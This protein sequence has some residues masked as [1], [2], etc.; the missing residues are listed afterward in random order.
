MSKK[1]RGVF[2]K[3][4]GSGVWWIHYYDADGHRRRERVGSKSNA[5][6]LYQK[7]KTQ[8]WEGMKVPENLRARPVTF[9]DLAT[10]AL[11]YSKSRK[12][13]SHRDDQSRMKK[14]REKF[15]HCVAEKITPQE[16]EG[17]L[18]S[19]ADWMPATKNRYLAL[20]KLTYRLG[21]LNGKIRTSP[22]RLV[23][24]RRENNAVVR[25]LNQFEPLPTQLDYLK[26]HNDEESRLRAV[27][28]KKYPCHMPELDVALNTGM[29][30][31]E[32]YGLQWEHV[33]LDQLVLTIPRSKHGE[34]RHIPLNAVA[35][36]ALK[37]LLP[38][39]AKN[40]FVFIS[41][42]GRGALQGSRH[43][44]E[45]ALKEAGVRNFTWHC[46]RHSFASRMVLAGVDL[47][48][49]QE[50]MGHKT[51]GMTIR[52]AHLAPAH[53]LAAVER[54]AVFNQK[55]VSGEQGVKHRLSRL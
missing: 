10:D 45:R 32:Q 25:Y 44:F 11:E 27:I 41:S 26:S 17:W 19:H 37:S 28:K 8:A 9:S 51:I 2:E 34:V 14:I 42:R 3:V 16:I 52:Y 50:L 20:M 36:G 24:M 35:V 47:R 18:D 6:R 15:A 31:G 22:A 40:N 39:M 21:E 7:R 5:T 49:V 55:I 48:T 33:N 13:L 46:L 54:L 1:I 4:P 23:R 12:P 29:R 30:R 38:N 53:Q 43:W